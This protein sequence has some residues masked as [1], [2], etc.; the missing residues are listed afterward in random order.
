[1]NRFL[2]FLL[3]IA[4]VF[5]FAGCSDSGEIGAYKAKIAELEQQIQALELLSGISVD[6]HTEQSAPTE[7]IALILGQKETITDVLEFTIESC[8]W[9]DQI[10]P[11]NT[12]GVYSYKADKPDETYLVL[13]GSLTNLNGNSY[14]INNLHETEVLVNGKYSFYMNMDCEEP[15]GSGFGYYVKPLQTV[16][17][18]ICSSV[19]DGVKAIFENASVTINLLND[20]ERTNYFF[21][22]DD[23]CKNVYTIQLTG[24]QLG[25]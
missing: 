1:M 13:R 14:N 9:E 12:S 15:D 2:S 25:A 22:R 3:L 19:S 11:S 20:P 6:D 17:F 21:D 16:N 23:A 10:L 5:S 4:L 24:A 8:T 7:E 18:V